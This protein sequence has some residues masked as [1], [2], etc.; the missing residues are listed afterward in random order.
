VAHASGWIVAGSSAQGDFD[1]IGSRS[2][3]QQGQHVVLQSVRIGDFVALRAFGSTTSAHLRIHAT[4]AIAPAFAGDLAIDHRGVSTEQGGKLST[5][6]TLSQA[7]MNRLAFFCAYA[8]LGICH[9]TQAP[10][11]RPRRQH[12]VFSRGRTAG[13]KLA[14]APFLTP[15]PT[16]I[17]PII[18][19]K[20]KHI[21]YNKVHQVK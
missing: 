15:A 5:A 17:P 20:I 11:L 1:L 14:N 19:P 10:C 4:E 2:G 9:Q 16:P 8:P 21:A 3:G 18:N 12:G 7:G 6:F 13:L